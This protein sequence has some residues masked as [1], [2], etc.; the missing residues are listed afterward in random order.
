M[1]GYLSDLFVM[2]QY[3]NRIVTAMAKFRAMGRN[4]PRRRHVQLFAGYGTS[5]EGFKRALGQVK[6]RTGH[7]DYPDADTV[8][9]TPS[10]IARAVELV[11]I[12]VSTTNEEM[13]KLVAKTE[14]L[15]EQWVKDM[16]AKGL[17]GKAVL[18]TITSLLK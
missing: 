11:P 13:Q 4:N 10:G 8:R 5:P 2:I 12:P 16:E 7:V 6:K 3:A 1:G 17:P 18:E 9:L 15:K 14:T